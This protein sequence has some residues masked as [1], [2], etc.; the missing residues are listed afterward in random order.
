MV[1][2]TKTVLESFLSTLTVLPGMD[3]QKVELYPLS[4]GTRHSR[5]VEY[6]SADAALKHGVAEIT[7]IDAGGHV[8]ELRFVNRGNSKVFII[9]GQELRGAKQNRNNAVPRRYRCKRC[10]GGYQR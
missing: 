7:E 4:T 9:D 10:G 3:Y 8:P 1:T 2:E 6:Q 5:G